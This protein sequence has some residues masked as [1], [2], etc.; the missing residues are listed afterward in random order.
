MWKT[1]ARLPVSPLQKASWLIFTDAAGVGQQISVQLRGI[2]QQ[3]V[4]VA[5]GVAFARLRSG[6][7]TIRPEAKADYSAFVSS[8]LRHEG[9]PTRILYLWSI[10]EDGEAAQQ[11]SGIAARKC[12]LHELFSF[13]QEIAEHKPGPIDFAIVLN[14]FYSVDGEAVLDLQPAGLRDAVNAVRETFPGGKSRIIDVDIATGTA[15]AAVQIIAEHCSPFR[16]AAVAYRG[17]S[18]WIEQPNQTSDLQLPPLSRAETLEG[19]NPPTSQVEAKLMGWWKELLGIERVGLDDDFFECGG[20]SL[21]AVQM[22]H[23]IDDAYKTGFSISILFEARTI[24]QLAALISPTGSQG[25]LCETKRPRS[26]VP[27]HANGTKPPLF[28]ISGLGGN[29]IKFHGLS[30]YLGEDVPM[31]G[32]LPRGLDGKEPYLTTIE[33]IAAYHVEALRQVAP[34][35]PYFLIG[36]SFGGMVAFE[37]AQQLIAQGASVA[38]VGM[39]DTIEWRYMEKVQKTL[40]TGKRYKAYKEQMKSAVSGK[41]RLHEFKANLSARYAK[42]AYRTFNRLG[43][44]IPQTVGTIE[45]VNDFASRNY[46]PKSYP[47]KLTIFRSTIRHVSEGEDIYLGWK[48]L[49]SEIEV[50]QVQSN[51]LNILQEPSVIDIAD[52]LRAILSRN[53]EGPLAEVAFASGS[54]QGRQL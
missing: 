45:I 18:R 21:I 10:D 30:F 3:V 8:L 14:R 46:R 2:Q 24:R 47:G 26:I 51:H 19:R 11:A 53:A 33:E 5:R 25:N 13:G 40:P 22:F 31:F 1:T 9:L 50:H 23:R 7:Y 44:A 43:K 38:F 29:V 54:S 28:V 20:D 52:R 48:D 17:D 27:I 15:T 36:Y 37:V 16:D 42:F 12:I 35:G 39:L 4:E 49:A 32:L 6:H 41:G 34:T